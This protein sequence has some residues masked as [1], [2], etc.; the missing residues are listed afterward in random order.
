MVASPINHQLGQRTATVADTAQPVPSTSTA[1]PPFERRWGRSRAGL[2][3]EGGGDA[4][5]GKGGVAA[6]VHFTGQYRQV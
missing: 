1:P 6:R 4:Q 3:R 2:G 5:H